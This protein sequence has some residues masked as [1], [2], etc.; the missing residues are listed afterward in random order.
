MTATV[1]QRGDGSCVPPVALHAVLLSLRTGGLTG[2]ERAKIK[3]DQTLA[4]KRAEER[5]ILEERTAEVIFRGEAR[6]A[7]VWSGRV[8]SGEGEGGL[9]CR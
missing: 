8:G 9:I 5:R 7:G 3:A 4:A 2:A 6:G 1:P